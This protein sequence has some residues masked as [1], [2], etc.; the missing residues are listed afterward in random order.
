MLGSRPGGWYPRCMILDVRDLGPDDLE[1]DRTLK[2]ASLADL[3]A[4]GAT[5]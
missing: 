1:F 5:G 2:P 4:G 3:L